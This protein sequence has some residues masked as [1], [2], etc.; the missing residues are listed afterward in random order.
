MYFS[1][2]D[3][4]EF[5]CPRVTR[6]MPFNPQSGAGVDITTSHMIGGDP[7]HSM[8]TKYSESSVGEHFTSV[9]QLLSRYTPYRPNI[10]LAT[11]I[12]SNNAIWIWPFARS[13]TYQDGVTGALSGPSV[14]GDIFSYLMPMYAMYRGSINLY[15]SNQV[16]CTLA[17]YPGINSFSIPAFAVV[18]V[19][20]FVNG[21]QPSNNYLTSLTTAGGPINVMGSGTVLDGSGSNFKRIPYYGRNHSSFAYSSSNYSTMNTYSDGT[22]PTHGLLVQFTTSQP[23]STI[24][25]YARAAANDFQLMYFVGTIPYIVA[26]S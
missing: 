16:T 25:T 11:D 23:S 7:L 2:A 4:F 15:F 6:A 9:R 10:P 19:Q 18:P 22:Q 14:G 21:T 12:T 3:D 8:S 13:I 5:Q 26:Y 24:F 20:S 1:G 17:Q